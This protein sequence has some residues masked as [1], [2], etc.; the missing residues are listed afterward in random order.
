MP[1]PSRSNACQTLDAVSADVLTKVNCNDH[2]DYDY[3]VTEMMSVLMVVI[4]HL[5][6]QVLHPKSQVHY[7]QYVCLQF[8]FA[9]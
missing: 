9:L 5:K 1:T 3:F 8:W 4:Y 2:N 6:Y 7:A